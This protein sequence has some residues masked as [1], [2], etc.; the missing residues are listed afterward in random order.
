MTCPVNR[1]WNRY[2]YAFLLNLYH[3][4]TQMIRFRAIIRKYGAQGEKTGWSYID[5]PEATAAKLMPGNKKSFRVKG[6]LDHHPIEG[7]ALVPVGEGNFILAVNGSMRKALKKGEGA[8][9][10]VQLAVDHKKIEP[11]KDFIECLK[12]EPEA[13]AQYNKLPGSHRHYFTRW[14]ESAKTD[15]TRTRR[16]AQSVTA[17]SAGKGYADMLRSLKSDK[18]L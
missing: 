3:Q 11:P 15:A 17:L 5:I 1:V 2:L 18:N 4:S 16:I 14:I 8:S 10:E 9:I 12:D 7:V 13:L 6:R